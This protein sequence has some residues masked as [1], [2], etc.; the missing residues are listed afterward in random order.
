MSAEEDMT[1]GR[2]DLNRFPFP[3]TQ[4]VRG[5][6]LSFSAVIGSHFMRDHRTTVRI[7]YVGG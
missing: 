3:H 7:K 5:R 2:M 4:S 1:I 6:C